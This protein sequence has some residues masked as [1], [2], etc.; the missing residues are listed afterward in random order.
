MRRREFI[1]SL[2]GGAAVG[3]PLSAQGNTPEPMRSAPEPHQAGAALA[4]QRAQLSFDAERSN[5]LLAQACHRLSMAR[6]LAD[7][8]YN[9]VGFIP[10]TSDGVRNT[11]CQQS[12]E[13]G[14]ELESMARQRQDYYRLARTFYDNLNQAHRLVLTAMMPATQA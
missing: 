2:L 5:R 3:A 14:D 10:S 4:A 6:L 9:K 12:D 7:D 1:A 11:R 8:I 13:V